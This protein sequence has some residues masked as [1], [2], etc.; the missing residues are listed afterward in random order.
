MAPR[1]KKSV[2]FVLMF[3]RHDLK[4][5]YYCKLVHLRWLEWT[6]HIFVNKWKTPEEVPKKPFG[7]LFLRKRGGPMHFEF[8]WMEKEKKWAWL[9]E[10]RNDRNSR[11]AAARL[12][13]HRTQK[14]RNPRFESCSVTLWPM[15]PELVNIKTLSSLFSPCLATLVNFTVKFAANLT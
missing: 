4:N 2:Q 9:F 7:Q 13:R 3:D 15:F 10:S 6:K 5:S 12:V 11:K 14:V 8:S 1:A